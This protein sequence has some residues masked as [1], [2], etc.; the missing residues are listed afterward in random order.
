VSDSNPSALQTVTLS[1]TGEVL[2]ST[3]TLSPRTASV[4]FTRGQ[5][6]QAAINGIPSSDVTWAVDGIVGGNSTIGI[7]STSGLYTPPTAAAEHLVS[8]TSNADPS[9]SASVRLVVTN[10]AGTFTYHNDNAR[11]GQNLNETEL[12]T[13][14]VNQAQFGKLFSYPVDGQIYAQP[15]YV[16]SVSAPGQGIHNVVYVAT[17]HDGVYAFDA[18]GASTTPLWYDSF[19]DPARGITT[20]PSSDVGSPNISPEYGMT[21]TPVIDPVTGTLYVVARTKEVS[22]GIVN[23]VQRLHALAIATGEEQ[24]GSPVV[25]QASVPGHG[26]GTDGHGNVPFDS[27]HNNSRSGLLLLNGAVYIVWASPGDVEPF[28]GWVMGYDA[29]TLVQISVFNTSPNGSQGGIWQGGA[30]PAADPAGNIFVMTGNGSLSGRLGG[31]EFGQ[32]FL[33]LANGKGALTVADFFMPFNAAI[34]NS[35]D[36]DLGSTGPLLLPDQPTG[37]QHLLVGAGKEGK[38]YLVN[39]DN[40]GHFNSVDDSQIVQVIPNAVGEVG[41]LPAK[42]ARSMPGYWQNQIYYV[43]YKD[44]PKAFRLLNGL[45][46]V[47]PVSQSTTFFNYPGAVPVVSSN[48]LTN[49]IVWASQTIAGGPAILHAFDAANVARELYNSNGAGSRDLPGTAVKFAVPTV[50]N[51]KVYV[52]TAT[53]LDVYGLLP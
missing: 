47:T 8:A 49:G 33:Q 42:G 22:G 13:G 39:R 34:L 31:S 28:H 4:N 26:N 37:P 20:V 53:E 2:P 24:P 52:G 3:V 17:E 50:A 51:G 38:I 15:L 35:A 16:P 40:M 46:S 12:T 11:T 29:R 5:Q 21:G 1:G 18:D 43:G 23:Y 48:G 10:Y 25:I 27:L 41:T 9:Q 14:N 30:A 45:I 19:I 6:F 36:T 7:I 44:Y 32:T